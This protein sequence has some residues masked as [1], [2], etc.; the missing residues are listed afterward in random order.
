A[1]EAFVIGLRRELLAAARRDLA[2]PPARR[3]RRARRSGL[4]AAVRVQAPR[5]LGLAAA[6]LEAP[7]AL[8]LGRQ[9]ELHGLVRPVAQLERLLEAYGF[10]GVGAVA[11]NLARSR[12]RH[13][14][15]PGRREHDGAL[16]PLAAQIRRRVGA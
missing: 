7:L 9:H 12:Q 1:L 13:L 16:H 6:D 5:I 10:N 11:E 8:G 14:D 4:D 3:G 2:Q 15:V